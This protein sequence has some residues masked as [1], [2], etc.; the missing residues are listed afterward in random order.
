MGPAIPTTVYR[1]SG[2]PITVSRCPVDDC[3][4]QSERREVERHATVHL[5]NTILVAAGLKRR[6]PLAGCTFFHDRR[7]PENTRKHFSQQ[8]PGLDV[9]DYVLLLTADDPD[10]QGRTLKDCVA[11][12]A[13]H[14]PD[15]PVRPCLRAPKA[16]RMSISSILQDD[17]AHSQSSHASVDQRFVPQEG[18]QTQPVEAHVATDGQLGHGSGLRSVQSKGK[19]LRLRSPSTAFS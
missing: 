4:F 14:L 11:A 13:R 2:N 7:R 10:D 18:Q 8:H 6:C 16:D 9:N 17:E 12:A 19:V 3:H 15:I 1:G 5:D